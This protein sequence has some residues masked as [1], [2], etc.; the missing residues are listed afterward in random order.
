M[1]KKKKVEETLPAV[2]EQ[3]PTDIVEFAEYLMG[4]SHKEIDLKECFMAATDTAAYM[5]AIKEKGLVLGSRYV[6]DTIMSIGQRAATGHVEAAKFLF[7]FL[8]LTGVKK[9]ITII[10]NE[11]SVNVTLKDIIGDDEGDIIDV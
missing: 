5:M 8:G 3:T 4:K 6:S 1:A 10:N 2:V 11:N 9:P 7:N